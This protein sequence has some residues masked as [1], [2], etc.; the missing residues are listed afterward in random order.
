MEINGG[1]LIRNETN[2]NAMGGS[3]IIA[4]QIANRVNPDLLAEC[5]IIN[6]RVRNLDE[7]KIR[8]LLNHDLADDPESAILA[9]GGW[10][11]FHKIVFVSHWQ[12]NEFINKFNIPWSKCAVIKNAIDP[13][14]IKPKRTD[15]IRLGYWSTPHRGLN[16]LVPVFDK[17]CEKYDNIELDVY[18]SFEIYGWGD[19]DIHYKELF[20]ACKN[21]PKINYHGSVPNEEIRK[22]VAEDLHIL[23]YPNIWKETSCIVLMEAMSGGLMCVHPNY[24]ALPETASNLTCMYPWHEDLNAHAQ[25]FYNSLDLAIMNYS[26]PEVQG[27]LSIQKK[28]ADMN[29]NWDLRVREWEGLI[30]T[31]L[32][33]P[34]EIPKD[35]ITYN[36]I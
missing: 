2:Q 4:T 1:K 20:D 34:R 35:Y 7:S 28:L 8:I 14:D 27:M 30:R 9:N 36:T 23:A 22:A 5:Q 6:S 21:H 11:K 25:I 10:K 13:V 15:V 16:I 29:N 12:M 17:L 24:A 33:E 19:R 32:P 31:L 3:E 26:T 18:S